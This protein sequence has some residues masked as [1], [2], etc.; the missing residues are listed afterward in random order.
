MFTCR[1]RLLPLASLTSRPM[2]AAKEEAGVLRIKGEVSGEYFNIRCEAC[3]DVV[4]LYDVVWVGAVPQ[5]RAACYKCEETGDFKVHSKTLL[6]IIP[7]SPARPAIPKA[8][9]RLSIGS[10]GS[11]PGT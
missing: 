10:W 6:D 9:P 7:V 1:A 4:R 2:A 5:I 8:G 11:Y 3:N